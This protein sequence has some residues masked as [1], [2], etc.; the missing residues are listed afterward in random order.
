MQSLHR[1][2]AVQR[3]TQLRPAYRS[4][5]TITRQV[6]EN[7]RAVWR[8]AHTAKTRLGFD[9]ALRVQ[10][11]LLGIEPYATLA[12]PVVDQAHRR[13][14]GGESLSAEQ[15]LYSLFAPHTDLLKRGQAHR[16]VG[17]A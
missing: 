13:A 12:R 8:A 16:P 15:H 7:A 14:L 3:Q 10:G 9:A 11:L 4:L 6:I 17:F 5:L 1:M 2:S